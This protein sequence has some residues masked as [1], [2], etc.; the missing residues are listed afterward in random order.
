MSSTTRRDFLRNA[1]ISGIGV[2]SGVGLPAFANDKY[3]G[4][5]ITV[6]H[7]E[8]I[9]LQKLVDE[10]NSSLE[11]PG[12]KKIRIIKSER[13][14]EVYIDNTLIKQYEMSIGLVPK[15]DKEIQ[16]DYKTP[17]G[18]FY[19]A[20][21]VPQS[22]FHKALLL[23]Y[24]TQKHADQGLDKGIITSSQHSQISQ[25]I[26]KCKIVPTTPLGS[27]IEIHGNDKPY[28][29][30]WTH[31]CIAVTDSAMDEIYDFAQEGCNNGDFSIE[32]DR[33]YATQVKI[34]ASRHFLEER[35]DISRFFL[36]E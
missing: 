22:Q 1:T 5:K 35:S 36:E 13:L 28:S 11:G 17:V 29:N 9:S 15:G 2:L 3:P 32:D 34:E 19:V 20:K 7:N 23:N 25:A 16:G 14:L 12:H 6:Y 10:Y 33:R 8:D 30:D 24:P 26:K 31:G 4:I 21:K 27:L 18:I